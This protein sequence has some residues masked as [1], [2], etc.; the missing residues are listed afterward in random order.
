[1]GRP[2]RLPGVFRLVVL[3]PGYQVSNEESS[4]LRSRVGCSLYSFSVL[5]A[6]VTGLPICHTKPSETETGQGGPTSLPD[7]NLWQ[8]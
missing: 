5:I 6:R 4:P 8:L 3:G 7:T 2:G 1:M